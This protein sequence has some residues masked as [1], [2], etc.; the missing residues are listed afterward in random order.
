MANT[1]NITTEQHIID[2][3]RQVFTEKGFAEASMSD[4]AARVGI[5]RPAL[6]YY[7][8]TKERLYAT[9]Y[10]QIVQSFVPAVRDIIMQDMPMKDRI[11]RVVDI[12]ITAMEND[13]MLPLFVA[14]EIQRDANFF[15]QT[16]RGLGLKENS[17]RFHQL[18]LDEMERGNVRPLPLEHIFYTFCGLV[19]APFMVRPVADIAFPM[20]DN[21]RHDSLLRWKSLV[22]RQL[23]ALL[24]P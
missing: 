21:A 14:R 13:P 10:A 18:L 19:F 9:V 17:D 11:E 1:E 15:L 4:I 2:V 7:F 6:H 5:N 20:T 22:T 12:Y 23:I 8:R 3:A 24:C 16:V